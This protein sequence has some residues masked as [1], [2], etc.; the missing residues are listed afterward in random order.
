[1]DVEATSSCQGRA[2]VLSGDS[3]LVASCRQA[4]LECV[5]VGSAY[6]AAAELLAAPTIALIMDLRLLPVGHLKLLEIARQLGM[7]MF[8]VGVLPASMT[9]D[10]LSGLRLVSR[11]DLPETIKAVAD[12]EMLQLQAPVETAAPK[13]MQASVEPADTAVRLTP[14]RPPVET[15]V[16]QD[17]T[18]TGAETAADSGEPLLTP[19]EIDALLGNEQ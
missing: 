14:A 4:N 17:G 12:A 18:F 10:E 16:E 6:E 8:G 7:E 2:V 11:R 13:V 3:S 5:V 9:A 19:E 15:I 1:M